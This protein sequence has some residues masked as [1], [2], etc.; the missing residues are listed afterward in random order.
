[1]RV[2]LS[3]HGQRIPV[4]GHDQGQVPDL[5]VS[6][7]RIHRKDVICARATELYH[8]PLTSIKPM[9]S[10]GKDGWLKPSCI[11]H[12]RFESCHRHHYILR[13]SYDD[14]HRLEEYAGQVCRDPIPKICA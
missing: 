2:L 14:P 3:R 6:D 11:E 9:W 4:Q 8:K 10:S 13:I 1:M 5:E 7:V 12:R